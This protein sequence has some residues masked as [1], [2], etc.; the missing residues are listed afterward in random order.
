MQVEDAKANNRTQVRK[1]VLD[2]ASHILAE[3]G[4]QQL[5]MRKLSQKL[6]ASTIVL[7]TYFKDKQEIL[8]ELYLEGFARLRAD[9]EA[10][11]AGTDA[12]E[13]V[14]QLGRA[15]RA[16]AVRNP[17]YY[18]I[19]FSLCVPGFTPPVESLQKS[20]ATFQILVLGVQRCIDAGQAL[21]GDPDEIA[22]VL[23]GTL[24]GIISLE[25]FGYLGPGRIGEARLEQA[26]QTIK[27][28]LTHNN[29]ERKPS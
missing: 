10:V 9:L 15:Y 24:H 28:G 3:E 19:M 21:P 27:T 6:G 7:Y 4:P 22:E 5:S 18:Q 29:V 23:W 1:A 11:P 8:N 13:Y 17:T 14:M 25:L 12:M 20:K 2:C 16:S 26:I